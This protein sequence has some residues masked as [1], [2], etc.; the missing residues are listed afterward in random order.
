[1]VDIVAPPTGTRTRISVLLPL[2]LGGAYDYWA[3]DDIGVAPGDFITVPLGKRQLIGVAWGDG[4]G[5]VGEEKLR[6]IIARCDAPSLP[7]QSRRFI[8]W[9]ADYTV[10]A[11]GA[12]LRMA[13]GGAGDLTPPK[14]LIAYTLRDPDAGSA[15][16]ITPARS[17]VFET[18]TGV[19]SMSRAELCQTAGV[20]PAVVK[21]MLDAGLLLQVEL[22]H[23][24][25]FETP[26]LGH[27]QPKLTDA[28]L[29]AA[30]RLTTKIVAGGFSVALI[31]GV[32][33]SGKTEVY[34]EA[35]AAA[36]AEGGQVLVLVPE[37]ALTSQWL[38][39]FFDRFGVAPAI[40]HSD[41]GQA[42]RRRTWRAIANGEARVVVGARSALFLPF[43]ALGLIIVDEEHEAA[44]KQEDGAHYHARDMAVVRA[45]IGDFP[46]I[47][48]SATPSLET[49]A[50][51]ER[52]RYD[53][54]HLPA[55]YGGAALP[56]IE[57]IDMRSDPPPRNPPGEASA[58]GANFISPTLREALSSTV[59]AGEQA[60][61]YLN[62]RGYAPLTLCCKCG[63]RMGCPN[64][65][66][67]LVEHRF[68]RRLQC[69]HCG[70]SG[71]VPTTCPSCATEDALVTCGPG[72]ERI[73]DEVA[74][75]L[76]DARQ[77]QMTSD[78]IRGP[79]AATELIERIE[80]HDIDIL[81]GTQMVAK[82]HHFPL[83]TLVGVIDAD[84]GLSGGDLRAG[85]RTYQLLHQV[86]GRAGRGALPGRVMLQTYMPEHP[87]MAAL[88]Q[89]DRQSFM[90][91]ESEARR[92]GGWP[93]YGRLA[94]LILSSRDAQAVDKL[95]VI[96]GRTAPRSD[97]IQVLGPAPAP[98]A[99]LRG[100]HRRR[101]LVKSGRTIN[102]QPAIRHWLSQVTI[103]S[104]VQVRVDIDPYNFL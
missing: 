77:A 18:L 25:S 76:P 78:T 80:A 58:R 15:S 32:T 34:F 20:S 91:A 45:M 35:V 54:V 53:V 73:A 19:A 71:P 102:L 88:L 101:L 67:W 5:D 7:E 23:P 83:L 96:L 1:M 43:P 44:F 40:W 13:M 100:R 39:R 92:A 81:I 52:G 49:L 47:L 82:G 63:H 27:F 31:D 41:I 2:P 26:D 59:A 99:V 9:V 48:A 89:G 33:G 42:N 87:V 68:Q 104:N 65:D 46:A 69:H 84:L 8:D 11:P 74:G 72:V 57:I 93:P 90:H 60:L 22:P 70:F 6:E 4:Q 36:L 94:A 16:R 66:T 30:D 62:R 24:A 29:A 85:E 21:G 79:A 10:S 55:R 37:I 86:A 38:K 51:V 98:L 75:L 64:C 56:Q 3:P 61:L 97:D 95:A 50:N 17:R 28:Q 14:P 12:I 103:P